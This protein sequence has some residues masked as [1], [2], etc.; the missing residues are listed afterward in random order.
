MFDPV[1]N[2]HIEAARTA[3]A[4][5]GLDKLLLVPCANP[6]HRDPATADSR[7]RLQML[8][9]AVANYRR[10]EVDDREIRRQGLSYTVDTL[11]E[12]RGSEDCE[13]LVFVLG[14]DSFNTLIRWH[15]WQSILNLCHLLVL[16]RQHSKPD[17]E[18]ARAVELDQRRVESADELFSKAVGN[19][20]IFED[21]DAAVSSTEVRSSLRMN[22]DSSTM[23]DEKVQLYIEDNRLYR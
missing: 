23:L 8:E 16:G 1:H 11:A 6:N 10:L 15:E 9:L 20:L 19:I 2:G 7:Q 14:M 21:F 4:E 17:A 22:E 12:L 5:L 13:Q 3:V 18:I